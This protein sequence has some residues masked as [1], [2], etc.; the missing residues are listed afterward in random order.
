MENKYSRKLLLGIFVLGFIFS[1]YLVMAA[2]DA[3]TGLIFKNGNSTNNY[4]SDGSFTLNWTAGSNGG[5]TNYTIFISGA[6]DTTAKN[7]STT[8]YTFSQS[9]EG[10]YSF[11]VQAENST[12]KANSTENFWMI[13]D[14]TN[15]AVE[16]GLNSEANDSGANQT[17]IFVNVSASDTNNDSIVYEL[18]N[19]T[20]RV[21]ENITDATTMNWTGLTANKKYTF[22]VT[23][24][25]SATNS[26]NTATRT[27]YLDDTKPTATAT[28]SPSIVTR[29]DTFPCTC[30]TSDNLKL[31]STT[32]S[33]TSGTVSNADTTGTFTYTCKATDKAGFTTTSTA[34]YTVQSTGG[35]SSSGSS[36]TTT[37]E[38]KKNQVLSISPGAASVVKNFD[39]ETGIEEISI[40]V[41]NQANDVKITVNKYN[42]KPAGVS[43]EKSGNVYQ[44]LEIN[45]E[46]IGNKLSRATVTFKVEKS[47]VS[48]N[49]LNMDEVA[50]SKFDETN[51]EW[52][53]LTTTFNSENDNFYYYDVELDSFS[54][55]AIGEKVV[56]DEDTGDEV[57]VSDTQDSEE[58]RDLTWLW[59]VI[60]III[61]L[62]VA[63][64]AAWNKKNK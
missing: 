37:S 56:V 26:N 63:G 64:G 9:T 32:E 16:Y 44:Y 25:D 20:G 24:N 1:A 30:S 55:F 61:L 3:P 60:A 8:G 12:D 41:N 59:V 53:E 31:S 28:C 36:S 49:G 62:A 18:W 50:V 46:N 21:F 42:G 57:G 33:S 13:V 7:D 27:F 11:I 58:E 43:I 6:V 5:A 14:T 52:N 2:I 29:G 38:T 35:T 22:N 15:P 17:W 39:D 54:Y 10:N 40:E 45:E 4:D 47:W 34:E 48:E 23:M 51:E 19:T